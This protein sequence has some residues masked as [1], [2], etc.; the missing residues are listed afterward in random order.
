M[1]AF[2][3]DINDAFEKRRFECRVPSWY[4]EIR[5][6]EKL[7]EMGAVPD[8]RESSGGKPTAYCVLT[9]SQLVAMHKEGTP[10]AI[11]NRNDVNE[12]DMILEHY[13]KYLA[14]FDGRLSSVQK[15]AINMLRQDIRT[16]KKDLAE[17]YRLTRIARGETLKRPGS[18]ISNLVKRLRSTR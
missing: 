1:A 9:C 13:I 12:I 8:E 5:Y 16:F 6:N 2:Y 18:T 4:S 15:K 10:F 7:L 3:N 14:G 11:V 17:T